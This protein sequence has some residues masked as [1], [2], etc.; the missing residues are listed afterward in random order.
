[1]AFGQDDGSTIPEVGATTWKLGV[2]Q[3]ST[4]PSVAVLVR[5]STSTGGKRGRG[6]FYLPWC[7]ATT[8]VDEAG[9]V[10]SAAQANLQTKC[11]SFKSQLAATPSFM[12]LVLLHQVGSSTPSLITGLTVDGRV[13]TQRRRIGR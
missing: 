11:D 3:T 2:T 9:N 13:A 5:K 6:R 4:P 12:P 8:S 7:L 1:M 10:A